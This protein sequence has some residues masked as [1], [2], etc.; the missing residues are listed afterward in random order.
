MLVSK[1]LT[2][3]Q[4]PTRA[5]ATGGEPGALITTAAGGGG[6]NHSPSTMMSS[7]AVLVRLGDVWT[8]VCCSHP[9]HWRL[10][11]GVRR[12]RLRLKL[13][14]LQSPG[15]FQPSWRC[16]DLCSPGCSGTLSM[17]RRRVVA[18]RRGVRVVLHVHSGLSL[19]LE[20]SF[21]APC[22][23]ELLSHVERS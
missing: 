19:P 14:R 17:S 15:C 1:W 22:E 12:C 10:A 13:S 21:G 9:A 6:G 4:G 20:S 8:Q 11:I 3:A 18:R 23:R 5:H 2:E 7:V 16:D